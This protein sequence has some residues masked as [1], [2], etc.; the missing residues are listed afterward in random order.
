MSSIRPTTIN[1]FKDIE[2]F[3]NEKAQ[4]VGLKFI[5]KIKQFCAKNGLKTDNFEENAQ[6]VDNSDSIK[7]GNLL[8]KN[9]FLIILL[10]K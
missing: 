5:E 8:L 9:E 2:D 6:V 4:T 7:V 3:A 1:Y 10:T